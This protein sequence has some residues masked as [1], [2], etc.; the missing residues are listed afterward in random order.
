MKQD[1]INGR[2]TPHHDDRDD[3]DDRAEPPARAD[4]GASAPQGLADPG[5]QQ[6][7]ALWPEH[8]AWEEDNSADGEGVGPFPTQRKPP[9]RAHRRPNA[10][11]V[12]DPADA[13]DD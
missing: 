5:A 8:W 3:E 12:E 9:K 13:E 2:Q 4:A 11:V 6:E 10:G 7:L 1:A